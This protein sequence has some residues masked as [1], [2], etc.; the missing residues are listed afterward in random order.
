MDNSTSTQPSRHSATSD[1]NASLYILI[2]ISFYGFFLCVLLL[3]YIRSKRREKS[4]T[5]IFTKLVHDNEKREWGAMPKKS[6]LSHTPSG[7]V[8][9]LPFCSSHSGHLEMLGVHGAFT[10]NPLACAQCAEQSSVSSLCSS[11]SDARVTI[12][13]EQQEEAEDQGSR[14]SGGGDSG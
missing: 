14:R 13:E 3:G 6:S 11:S 8:P 7:S 1:G 12:E 4:R 2:V 9:T 10:L 5:N